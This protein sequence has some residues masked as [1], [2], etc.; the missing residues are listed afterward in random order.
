MQ[1]CRTGWGSPTFPCP[2]LPHLKGQGLIGG[3][4]VARAQVDRP[5]AAF[6]RAFLLVL[7]PS[8]LPSPLPLPLRPLKDRKEQSH[9]INS[10]PW[11][12]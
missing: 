5:E 7:F 11:L 9:L 10:L 3:Q 6:W 1:I 4:Q 2:Q 12:A 8:P